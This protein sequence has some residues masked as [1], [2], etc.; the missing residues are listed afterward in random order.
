[1]EGEAP[2]EPGNWTL[3]IGMTI[4]MKTKAGQEKKRRQ[5]R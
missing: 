4:A 1:M 2:A 5:G 3:R